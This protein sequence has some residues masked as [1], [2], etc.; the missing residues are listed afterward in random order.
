ML[1]LIIV[2]GIADA[3]PLDNRCFTD[4]VISMS[5]DMDHGIAEICIKDDISIVKTTSQQYKN[6]SI[7]LNTVQRKM[8]VSNYEDCN[9]VEAKNGPIMIFRPNNDMMLIPHTFACRVQCTISLDEEEANII[10]HSEKLNHYEVMGTT[11]ANRWF[12]G[13]TSYSLEHTCEHIQVTCGSTSLSFHACFKYH[14]AC[15]RLLNKS[16]MPAFMI[17]SVCQNKELIIMGCLVL[18]IFGILYIMT[19]TYI[20][21]ILIPIFYPITYLY[22]FIYNKSCKKCY[23]CGLAYHPLTKC[24]TNCV[25]GCM[26]ENSER[27]KKHRESGMCKG[28]K[29]LR[30][31]RILCKNRGSS[32]ILA[33]ILSFLL[34]SFIQPIE[35]VKITYQNEIIELESIVHELEI[36][37]T[38]LHYSAVYP[39][40]VAAGSCLILIILALTMLLKEKILDYFYSRIV[41]YCNE[42]EMTHPWRG[43]TFFGDF[44]NRCN[45]CM[46]G[47]DQNI[48]AKDEDDYALPKYH[49]PGVYCKLPGRYFAV[50]KLDILSTRFLI[51]VFLVLISSSIVYA[52][53]TCSKVKDNTA[54]S[55]P[56]QCSVWYRLP[57]T[58]DNTLTMKDFMKTIKLPQEDISAAE[59]MSAN[60]EAMLLESEKFKTA[61]GSFLIESSALK[62]HCNE[63]SEAKKKT[64]RQNEILGKA[65]KKSAIEVC[66]SGDLADLCK[67]FRNEP[68]CNANGDTAKAI[69]YYK[70]HNQAFRDDVSKIITA[71]MRIYP[72]IL[73]REF[74]LSL[75]ADNFSKVKEIA[76]NM[77]GKFGNAESITA[78]MNYLEKM[79]AENELVKLNPKIS[80]SKDVVPYSQTRTNIFDNMADAPTI[81][82]V[83]ESP[84]IYKCSYLIASRFRFFIT[85]GTSTTHFYNMPDLGLSYQIGSSDKLCVADPFC[86]QNFGPVNISEK[87]ELATL[88]CTQKTNTNF[89][90]AKMNP[91]T[92]C[93]KIS[94][95]TCEYKQK[96]T[97]FIECKNTYFYEYTTIHQSPGDDIGIYCF[98]PDCRKVSTPHH[99]A[100]LI[101]CRLHAESVES[102]KLKEIIY[103]NIEQ[104]KH[105]IQET[106][107]TDL[108]EHKYRLTMNLPKVNPSFKALSI[109]GTETDGGVESAYIETNILAK[110]GVST[111]VTL[112]TKKGEKLFD[113]IL[114]VKSAHYE[115]VSDLIYETGPTVGINMQ[116]DEQC[117]GTC[118]ND[119]KKPGWLSFSKEHTSTWGCEEFGCLAI[120]SG[121]LYG[122]CRDIVKP[123]IS[124]YKRSSEEIPKISL[125]ISTPD[126]TYCHDIDSFNPIITEKLE[127]Q[128]LSNEAGK[129]PKIFGYKSN[130]VLTGMINDKGS[131]AKMCGSVQIYGKEVW[132]AGNPKF[133]YIC[134]A[135]RRKDVTISRCFDNFY[136]GCQLLKPEKDL[137]FDDKTSKLLLL[138]K[139]MGEIRIKLKL[140]DIKYKIFEKNPSMDAKAVCV[141]CIACTK[142]LDCELDIISSSDTI[143]PLKS[144]CQLYTNNLKIESNTQKYG[145][146][147]K[148]D[149]PSISFTICTK[150]ID[151]QIT[152]LEKKEI[153]EV[154][155]SDQT[156]FVKEKDMKCGTWL[157]KVSEQGISSIFSPFLS[158]FGSY[159]KI[160]FYTI[161]A[162]ICIVIIGYLLFP[163]CVRFK[164]V[165]KKNEIEYERE[166]YGYKPLK[167]Y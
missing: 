166:M 150:E 158:I 26:F 71:I 123:E 74:G 50:R 39:Q 136:E 68:N 60:L 14:M 46:C 104:L 152:I 48:E 112:H 89:N 83:C 62:L 165:L 23:Y 114:F 101:G 113:M 144:N 54:I 163:V 1:L 56:L 85:C 25:C 49:K 27:M 140:G 77:K 59:K 143:C 40:I 134:H 156:Y 160:A 19:M 55:N 98:S 5:K 70:G 16:Y 95:Q 22:G 103:E 105:S 128:F 21:Y 135:A 81:T 36:I 131:F 149:S 92:K 91:L 93:H 159:A 10:L 124:V 97:T 58:C 31:A 117:T 119:L 13:T 155:N 108:I 11:T 51:V 167:R 7:Y 110:T 57:G 17:H 18:I 15:I 137:I 129:S 125:C 127:I 34:L 99:V 65:L 86:E 20:C 75:K 139:L 33:I 3:V 78:C 161:L 63:L 151:A 38:K 32:F 162:V 37:T 133:D 118:P 132:G 9:P 141:G 126:E 52:T 41:Y 42:C 29:S 121:C 157:C 64:G 138:N 100:N 82:K 115:S 146:K 69:T 8:L 45:T 4:G 12:Q 28:Y 66:A 96:N 73:A 94:A 44:T 120:G 130:K 164:D 111:G 30:A 24:G 87:D 106:I 142:G 80:L 154:G 35:G 116:H 79:L 43:L 61:I 122:H 53:D 147:A 88:T 153:I 84:K 72:G 90:F 2:L 102:R 67:C 109:M 6:S 47:C 76:T 107:K 145:I 148:C